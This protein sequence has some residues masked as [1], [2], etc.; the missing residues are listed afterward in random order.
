MVSTG[1]VDLIHIQI[2]SLE[3]ITKKKTVLNTVERLATR[4]NVPSDGRRR[5]PRRM[6]SKKPT[7]LLITAESGLMGHLCC[8]LLAASVGHFSVISTLKLTIRATPL[9]YVDTAKKP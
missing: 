3:F 6:R 7:G 1:N 4:R 8:P 5:Q 9:V 2:V